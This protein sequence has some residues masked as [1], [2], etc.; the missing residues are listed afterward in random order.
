MCYAVLSATIIKT[1]TEEISCGTMV[2]IAPVPF[3]RSVGSMPRCIETLLMACGGPTLK[4][5]YDFSSFNLSP[6]RR[7]DPYPFSC[8]LNMKSC[9]HE[10]DICFLEKGAELRVC[11]VNYPKYP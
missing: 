4:A 8:S 9:T 5:C 10:I 6:I 2:L 1:P 7:C 11:W 3:Q